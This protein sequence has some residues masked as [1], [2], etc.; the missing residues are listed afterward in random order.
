[1]NGNS[2]KLNVFILPLRDSKQPP[3][4][5]WG[6]ELN[7]MHGAFGWEEQVGEGVKMQRSD[8]PKA[9]HLHTCIETETGKLRNATECVPG[10]QQWVQASL[11]FKVLKLFERSI[12]IK[13]NTARTSWW[14]C[15]TFYVLCWVKIKHFPP[16]TVVDVVELLSCELFILWPLAVILCGVKRSSDVCF[17]ALCDCG[18]VMSFLVDPKLPWVSVTS[19][20]IELP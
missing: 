9:S 15:S 14:S 1:M 10:E 19:R 13:T 20:L 11:S 5:V 8:W 4:L 3:W 7:W 12:P 6:T 2:S 16:K 17:A 18:A